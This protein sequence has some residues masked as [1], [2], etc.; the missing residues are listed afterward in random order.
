[1]GQVVA[2]IRRINSWVPTVCLLL[3]VSMVEVRTWLFVN[4]Y[5]LLAN[6]I[7][8]DC[9]RIQFQQASALFMR[10]KIRSRT[11]CI[12]RIQVLYTGTVGDFAGP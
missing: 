11:A 10:C 5:H 1:M 12:H 8:M 6:L 9:T 7:D 2:Y 4:E 3:F